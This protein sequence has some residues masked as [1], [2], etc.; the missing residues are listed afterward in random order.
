MNQTAKS[1]QFWALHEKEYVSPTFERSPLNKGRA[2][3]TLTNDSMRATQLRW[4]GT[5]RSEALFYEPVVKKLMVS[6]EKLDNKIDGIKAVVRDY[7]TTAGLNDQVFA[8]KPVFALLEEANANLKLTGAVS[9]SKAVRAVE[10]LVDIGSC[11]AESVH[12]LRIE[13]ANFREKVRIEKKEAV[14]VE[15]S[16]SDIEVRCSHQFEKIQRHI[17]ELQR[18]VKE[19]EEYEQLY[20]SKQTRA[21]DGQK[22]QELRALAE[23]LQSYKNKHEIALM[24]FKNAIDEAMGKLMNS[25]LENQNLQVQISNFAFK[26]RQFAAEVTQLKKTQ[27]RMREVTCMQREEI[28]ALKQR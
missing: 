15:H 4:T 14:R 9:V 5:T 11:L 3:N 25:D 20:K 2:L 8:N 12:N 18:R 17:A 26:E 19:L 21:A 16:T 27:D 22:E 7:S 10:T 13:L 6:L 28:D 23:E 24:R 1:G